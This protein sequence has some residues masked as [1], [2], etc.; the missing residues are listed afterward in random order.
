[1]IT[2]FEDRRQH[3]VHRKGE[4]Y[5]KGSAF[6]YFPFSFAAGYKHTN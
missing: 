3:G 4:K 6:S 1:M 5:E 2:T